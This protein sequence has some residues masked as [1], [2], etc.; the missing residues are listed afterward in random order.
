MH[1]IRNIK[2]APPSAIDLQGNDL[3]NNAAS[4]GFELYESTS[5][6]RRVSDD[7]IT[8]QKAKISKQKHI[9]RFGEAGKAR[10][11]LLIVCTHFHN[12]V[13]SGL[14]IL[15]SGGATFYFILLIFSH[16]HSDGSDGTVQFL[17]VAA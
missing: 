12:S 15:P 1:V 9:F 13:T 17:D 3:V 14:L 10:G 4:T 5:P 7:C 2:Y 16:S 11:T 8:I 6:P